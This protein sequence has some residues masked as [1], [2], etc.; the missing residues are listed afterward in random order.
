[1]RPYDLYYGDYIPPMK[2]ILRTLCGAERVIHTPRSLGE[3]YRVA[4][5]EPGSLLR[6]NE[7]YDIF[8][9]SV[10]YVRVF[11][12]EGRFGAGD[13]PI[14]QEQRD[15]T[16]EHALR[17]SEQKRIVQEKSIKDL[18]EANAALVEQAVAYK[19]VAGAQ[20]N[21]LAILGPKL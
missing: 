4:Y 1:M 2:I 8:A 5:S 19:R 15:T 13:L 12:Y 3:V 20:A 17:Q 10:A 16:Q 11:R 18:L 7:P 6:A 21:L 14:Y 9:S